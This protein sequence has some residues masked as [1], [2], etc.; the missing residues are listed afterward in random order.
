MSIGPAVV[1]LRGTLT[2][3]GY[4]EPA[5]TFDGAARL[6]I[7]KARVAPR[8]SSNITDGVRNGVVVGLTLYAPIGTDIVRTDRVEIG[9]AEVYEIDGEIGEW[10]GLTVKGLEVALRRV[11]G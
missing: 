3:D 8:S 7:R 1:R 9:G 6:T 10:H 11:D 4:N 5:W 2:T